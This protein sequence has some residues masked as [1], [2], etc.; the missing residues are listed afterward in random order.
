MGNGGWR[1]EFVVFPSFFF[2]GQIEKGIK[3]EKIYK[4]NLRRRENLEAERKL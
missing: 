1:T 2:L 4:V 3:K